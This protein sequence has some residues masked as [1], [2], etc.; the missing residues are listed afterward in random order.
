MEGIA[1]EHD[2]GDRIG[3][4]FGS[5]EARIASHEKDLNA[6]VDQFAGELCNAIVV[7]IRASGLDCNIHA[8]DIPELPETFAEAVI[9]RKL[10][11]IVLQP[12]YARDSL[13]TLRL[14]PKLD[15]GTGR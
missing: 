12:S 7:A 11:G 8:V 6:G 2:D 3:R 14:R 15:S 9:G 10:S 4:L 5:L 1:C 13:L